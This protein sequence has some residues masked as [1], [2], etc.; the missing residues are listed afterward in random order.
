MGSP[1]NGAIILLWHA[2]PRYVTCSNLVLPPKKK[3]VMTFS[4]IR[5]ISLSNFNCKIFSKH[6]PV[7]LVH[8]FPYIISPQQT[9]F[10]S[11][12]SIEENVLLVQEIMHDI[13]IRAKPANVGIKL[14]MTNTYER[15]SWLFLTKVLWEM[16]F[17]EMLID[18]VFRIISKICIQVL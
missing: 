8:L 3:E 14:N 9:G 5:P 16:G 7:R 10:V 6:F 2:L 18:M 15:L 12:R 17:G 4:D 13:R 11:R 1:E